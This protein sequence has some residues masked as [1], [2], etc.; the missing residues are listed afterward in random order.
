MTVSSMQVSHPALTHSTHPTPD[1]VDPITVLDALND[2]VCR[3]ILVTCG[4][5]AR[6]AQ[7]CAAACDVPLSTVYRK[8]GVLTD[9]ALLAERVRIDAERN[10]PSEFSTQFDTLSVSLTGVDAVEIRQVVTDGG[11]DG[12]EDEVSRR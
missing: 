7:E 11:V 6:T 10:F 1:D 4:E 9:A 3:R 5:R 8:L 2:G 12:D